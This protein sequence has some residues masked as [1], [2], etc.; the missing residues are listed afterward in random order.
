M[1]Y[2]KGQLCFTAHNLDPMIVLK[3]NKK[4]IDFLTDNGKL[5]SWVKNGNATPDNSY[6]NGMIEEIPFNI[7]STDFMKIFGEE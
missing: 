6:R 1:Y 7:D 5:V 3:E 4:S 2:G